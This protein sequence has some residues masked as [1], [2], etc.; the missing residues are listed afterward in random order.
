ML[1]S[2]L[3][4]SN[5][6]P[7]PTM[8]GTVERFAALPHVQAHAEVAGSNPAPATEGLTKLGLATRATDIKPPS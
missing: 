3:T 2:P 8:E 7:P 1:Q 4:D 5:R 6:R